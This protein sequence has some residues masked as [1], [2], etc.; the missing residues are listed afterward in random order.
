[1]RP[2]FRT[3]PSEAH[4]LVLTPGTAP[5]VTYRVG[6][7]DWQSVAELTVMKLAVPSWAVSPSCVSLS[8][9]ASSGGVSLGTG[10]AWGEDVAGVREQGSR[11]PRI[12][13]YWP[14]VWL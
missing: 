6:L 7:R 1:M 2:G 14:A 8:G 3:V 10:C 4:L 12:N 9:E 11:S 5:P 13:R